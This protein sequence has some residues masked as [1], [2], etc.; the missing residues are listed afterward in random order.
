MSPRVD[1][2]ILLKITIFVIVAGIL[3]YISRASLTNPKS[4]GF[5]RFFAWIDIAALI[6]INSDAWFANPLALHQIIS[7]ILLIISIVL[8]IE[9][10]SLLQTI[11]KPDKSRYDNTLLGME[12]TTRL[13]VVGLYKYIRHPLYSS[14]LFLGWG[15]F[16]KSISII[17]AILIILATTG[18]IL[19]ARKEERENI[20]YFGGE[21]QEY[22]KK[23]RMFI[24]YLL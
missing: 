22:M 13:V 9:G 23:T 20:A 4:H 16:F 17:S 1:L 24:P 12:K 8:V 3:V 10:I 5:Y 21:Y 2:M 18:L 7:W 14:L 6:V 19:T 15:V 11:G